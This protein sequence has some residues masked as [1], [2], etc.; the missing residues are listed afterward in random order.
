MEQ[1]GLT[2]QMQNLNSTT[3]KRQ[4]S[5]TKI[6]YLKSG[7]LILYFSSFTKIG[8]INFFFI[9]AVRDPEHEP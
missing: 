7:F 6:E 4:K 8:K 9:N 1:Y 5:E 3:L 2:S